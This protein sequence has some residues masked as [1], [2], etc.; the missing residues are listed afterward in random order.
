MSA[1]FMR[2]AEALDL[3][4]GG[5]LGPRGSFRLSPRVIAVRDVCHARHGAHD[6]RVQSGQ[7]LRRCLDPP[8]DQHLG[9]RLER[10]PKRPRRARRHDSVDAYLPRRLVDRQLLGRFRREDT[11]IVIPSA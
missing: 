9:H 10:A 3:R 8:A 7:H 6:G 11:T 1:T 2:G 4:S 5:D